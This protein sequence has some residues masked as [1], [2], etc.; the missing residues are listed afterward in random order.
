MKLVRMAVIAVTVGV[1]GMA[2]TLASAAP[3][4]WISDSAGRLGSVDVATGAVL[5]SVNMGIPMTDIAYDP[6]GNLYG[7]TF[8]SL[9]RINPTT[10]ATTFVGIHG[11]PGGN[12]LVFSAGG[13]L[14]GAGSNSTLYTVNPTTGVATGLGGT[15]GGASSGDLAFNGGQLYLAADASPDQLR[16]ITLGSPITNTLVGPMGID[17]V[18]GFA[19][20]DNGVLY[21][22]AGTSIYSINTAT[23]ATA[24]VS[25]YGG[26][27]LSTA[28]GTSFYTEAGAPDPNP[29]P[30]PEPGTMLLLGGGISA[31]AL[32][33]RRKA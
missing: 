6:L 1:L 7:V 24:F 13:T 16:R 32:R 29:N 19:T 20:A 23:G 28:F 11:I 18:Y 33:R 30:V 10:G 5:T 15:T 4:L 12:A 27:T 14:Y 25:N 17:N 31:L 3:I 2:G 8:G 9:Y 26:P 22:V 21:G